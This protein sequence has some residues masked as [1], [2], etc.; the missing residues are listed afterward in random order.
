MYVP[1]YISFQNQSGK[2]K[3]DGCSAPDSLLSHIFSVKPAHRQLP[4][5]R[6]GIGKGGDVGLVHIIA[7]G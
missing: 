1:N 3:H 7:G 2:R 4:D 5:G 6:E